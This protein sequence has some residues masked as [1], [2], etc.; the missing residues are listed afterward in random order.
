MGPARPHPSL[1]VVVVAHDMARELPRTLRSLWPPYQRGIE[2]DDLEI[3][4]VDNGSGAPIASDVGRP[5]TIVLRI[6][7]APA[8]PAH[9]ANVGLEAARGA[10]VG[11]VIDGARMASPGLLAG[12]RAAAGLAERAVVTAPAWHL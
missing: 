11:L 4:V 2:A 12:A 10:L 9:A 6:D 5:G 1:S 3:L 7:P 8:S